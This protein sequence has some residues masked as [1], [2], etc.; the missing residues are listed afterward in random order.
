MCYTVLLI[1][2]CY[3]SLVVIAPSGKVVGKSRKNHIPRVGDFNE[4]R[5]HQVHFTNGTVNEQSIA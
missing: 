2:C 1:F 3:V 5:Y 4:V